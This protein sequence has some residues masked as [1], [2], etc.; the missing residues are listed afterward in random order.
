M[1]VAGY[2]VL[3]IT[4]LYVIMAENPASKMLGLNE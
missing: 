4:E 1:K 3:E 2:A